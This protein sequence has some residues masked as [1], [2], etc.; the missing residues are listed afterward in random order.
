[1]I[2]P[3]QEIDFSKW[4]ERTLHSARLRVTRLDLKNENVLKPKTMEP[5]AD[6]G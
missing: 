6:A 1:M 4:E 5:K 2:L 3:G